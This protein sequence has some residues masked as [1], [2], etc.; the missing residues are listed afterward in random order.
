MIPGM[1]HLSYEDRLRD[2]G[3]FSVENRRCWGDLR[4]A[5]QYLKTG[6]K[7]EGDRQASRICGDWTRGN[8][9]KRGNI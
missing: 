3:V 9:F 4:V 7:K 2:L 5:F 8:G 1:E 6:Y